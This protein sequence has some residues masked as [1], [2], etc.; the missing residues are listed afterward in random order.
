MKSI[1]YKSLKVNFVEQLE[2]VDKTPYSIEFLYSQIGRGKTYLLNKFFEDNNKVIYVTSEGLNRCAN[3]EYIKS[4]ITDRDKLINKMENVTTE[5]I[6]VSEYR[7]SL[8]FYDIQEIIFNFAKEKG[9][10]VLLDI[11]K[12]NDLSFLKEI[13]GVNIIIATT[14]KSIIDKTEYNLP[15]YI[16]EFDYRIIESLSK[17]Y[18]GNISLRIPKSLHFDLVQQAQREGISLNQYLLYALSSR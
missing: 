4:A 14:N 1:G 3:K 12:L 5:N 10:T 18:S 11:Y 17:S 9:Y 16:T 15:T 6:L 2:K 8:R 7:D 13:E